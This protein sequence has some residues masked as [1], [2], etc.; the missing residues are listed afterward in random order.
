VP[1]LV[2]IGEEQLDVDDTSGG[3]GITAGEITNKVYM[4]VC[5]LETAQIRYNA[6]AA[7][8]AGGT[9]GSPILNVGETIEVWG[10][11]DLHAFK[12]IRTGSTSGK[13]QVQLFGSGD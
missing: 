12:A 2:Q 10:Q 1:T 8:T 11:K 4:A 6:S 13:L 5:T 9:E 7:P 3:V